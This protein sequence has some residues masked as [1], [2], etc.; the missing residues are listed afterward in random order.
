MRLASRNQQI[1][2]VYF[3]AKKKKKKPCVFY[4]IYIYII[5]FWESNLEVDKV[6]WKLTEEWSYFLDNILVR[7]R[8]TFYRIVLLFCHVWIFLN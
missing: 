7:V 8:V 4:F 2:H 5:L 6:I 1:L 3:V